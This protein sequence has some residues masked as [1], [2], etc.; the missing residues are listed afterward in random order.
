MNKSDIVV[1]I[2]L[3]R[4]DKKLTAEY[5]EKLLKSE[6][7][8]SDMDLKDWDQLVNSSI[9]NAIIKNITST[10]GELS[11]ELLVKDIDLILKRIS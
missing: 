8:K 1:S 10:R 9:G 3:S 5:V 11:M 7:A 6:L 4:S 2:Y